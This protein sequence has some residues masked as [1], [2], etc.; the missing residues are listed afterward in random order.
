MTSREFIENHLIKMI[1]KETEKL[2]KAINDI[3]KIKKIIEGLDESKKL[4]IPVLTSKV[5]DSEGEIHFRETAYRRIDSLYEIHRRNLTNKEWAL[6]N[7]YFEKKKEFV[8]QV[9]KFQEF[10]S[11]YRFFLPNNA[12]DIQERVRK[13]LAKKGYLVDGYF[14]GNY[15]TWIGVYARPKDKPTY[16]DPNDGEAAD[17]QNQ[18]RVDGFKQD[19]SEWFEWEIKNNEL[20]SEV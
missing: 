19:F 5:N 11:K 2:T 7:E 14:E 3:I 15:E 9:A 4:T 12:Q 18:Y 13:T 6:W 10:A 20:V 17:L 16:L 8:I 1:V